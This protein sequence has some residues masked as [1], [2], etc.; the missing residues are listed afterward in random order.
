MHERADH[1][2]DRF[3]TVDEQLQHEFDCRLVESSRLVFRVAFGVLRHHE[4]AEDVAQEAFTKAYRSFAK[5]RDRNRFR[6]WI[7]R[8]TWRLALNKRR[9]DQRRLSR[10][11]KEEIVSVT[12]AADTLLER[13][14]A[15]QLWDAIDTLPEKLRLVVVLGGIQEHDVREV[16]LLLGLPEGTVKSRLFVARQRLKECLQWTVSDPLK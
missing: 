1:L 6:A 15:E 10:E 3:L 8:M 4:D 13:E 2:A 14:R 11:A 7:V 16:A 5:L 9:T 12:T